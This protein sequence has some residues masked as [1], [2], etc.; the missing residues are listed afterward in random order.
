MKIKADRFVAWS[1]VALHR[2]LWDAFA[3]GGWWDGAKEGGDDKG[4]GDMKKY[5]Y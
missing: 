1:K 4:E 5:L 2:G 3:Y